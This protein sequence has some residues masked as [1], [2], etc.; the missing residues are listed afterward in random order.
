MLISSTTSATTLAFGMPG[1]WEWIFILVIGLLIFGRRLPEVGRSLGKGIVEF[2][3]GI[4]GIDDEIREASDSPGQKP[5][6]DQ[7]S[8]QEFS[9][10]D[11]ATGGEKSPYTNEPAT[12]EKTD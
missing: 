1:G 4:K 3:R 9:N 10:H 7:K 6:L 11:S 8:P 12:G 2:K 5:Q